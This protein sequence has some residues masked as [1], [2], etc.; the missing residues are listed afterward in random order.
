MSFQKR[1]VN[2]HRTLKQQLIANSNLLQLRVRAEGHPSFLLRYESDT[3]EDI[4]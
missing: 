4:F 1:A 3:K 2:F